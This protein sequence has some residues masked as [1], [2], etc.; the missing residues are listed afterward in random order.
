MLNLCLDNSLDS[1]LS[2]FSR[3]NRKITSD[4]SEFRLNQ[5]SFVKN[6]CISKKVNYLKAINET[7]NVR[8]PLGKPVFNSEMKKAAVD[9]LCNEHFVGGESVYKFEEEFAKYCGVAYAI[10]TSSGTNA[11]QFALVAAGLLRGEAVITSPASFVASSNSIIHAGGIPVFSDIHME[12]YTLNPKLLRMAIDKKTKA[13]IP[14]H[15]FGYPSNMDSINSVADEHGLI[16]VEDACQA[17]GALYKGRKTGSLGKIGCFSFYPSKNMTVGGDGGMITTNNK[18]IATTAAKLRD[19]GRK[20]KYVHDMIG[21]TARLNTVNAAIGRVQLRHLD[22]W[23]DK[24]R[25]V[26]QTY[27][28]LLSEIA[29]LTL[30][31]TGEI[32]KINPVFHCYVIRTK[33][34]DELKIWLESNGV[35]CGIHYALPIHLQ[36]VYKRL[37]GY[38]KGIYPNSE[39]LCKTCLSLPVYPDLSSSDLSFICEKIVDFFE[40]EADA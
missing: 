26:A 5:L 25:K 2:S 27:H 8:I 17:H 20:S 35:S 1:Y 40:G 34:R 7:S 29:E 11:L 9:A 37:F 3:T 22:G 13:I 23:N 39:E 6:F 12:T 10:S 21:Y 31:L 14:V 28:R 32:G 16:V 24:R 15:L 38:K 18:K 36:P 33:R 4:I 19:C 30:P